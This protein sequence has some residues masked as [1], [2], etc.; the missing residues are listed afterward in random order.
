MSLENFCRKPVVKILPERNVAEA[1]RVM[2]ENNIGCL[3]VENDGKL[4]GIIT[5]RD[6]ALKVA[7]VLR[8]PQKTTVKEIMTTDPIRISVDK[9]LRHLTSLMHAFH[10]RR[11]PIVNGHDTIVGIITL[12]DIIALIANEMSEIGKAIS[13]GFTHGSA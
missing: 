2:E 7:G 10:V 12:D 1:C 4:C 8:D 5:D 13:E 6:I 9:D 11:V 3:I